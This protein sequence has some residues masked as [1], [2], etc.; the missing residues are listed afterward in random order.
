[1]AELSLEQAVLAYVDAWNAADDAVRRDL[2]ERSFAA[3]G[4]YHDP[5]S[6]V[7]GREALIAHTRL[8]AQRRPGSTVS[9][10]SRIDVHD[11][12]GC[13][14]WRVA[15]PDGATLREGIDF[16]ASGAD[17]RLREVRGFFGTY[18]APQEH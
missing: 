13:F 18:R 9:V 16:V 6:A 2:L 3:D 4:T 1:M 10:T 12:V 7:V 8:L 14:T 5:A 11:G 15:G 17:G